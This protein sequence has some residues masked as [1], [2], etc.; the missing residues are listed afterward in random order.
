M[1][2]WYKPGLGNAWPGFWDFFTNPIPDKTV[3]ILRFHISALRYLKDGA[4]HFEDVIDADNLTLSVNA[5]LD[6]RPERE[7]KQEERKDDKSP[8]VTDSKKKAVKK[9]NKYMKKRKVRLPNLCA[10]AKPLSC[11]ESASPCSSPKSCFG[12]PCF[13]LFSVASSWWFLVASF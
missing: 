6:C 11:L 13:G 5:G 4:S 12:L 7:D 1:A 9:K 8:K 3:R 10:G 2:A